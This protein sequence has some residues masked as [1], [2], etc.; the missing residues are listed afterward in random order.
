MSYETFIAMRHLKSRRQSFLSTITIIAILGVFLGV[1]A[2]TSVLAVTGGFQEAFRER[3]LGVNSHILVIKHGIDFRDYREIQE[4]IEGVPG[5]VATSPFIF[6]EMIATHGNRSA[7]ILIKGIEPKTIEEV[8]DLPRYTHEP[9][10][11]GTLE[12]DRFPEDGEL[13]VPRV[14]LG[15]AL[16]DK[17][18]V[19]KGDTIQVTSPLESLDPS[20]WSSKEHRPASRFFEVAGTYRSGFHEY[21]SRLVMVDYRALQDF[22]NQGDVV[23]GVDIR[24][25]DVFAVGPI[26]TTLRDELPLGRFRVLDW[27]QLNHNLFTSLGLQRLVL[28]ILFLFIVLVASFNIVCTLIMIVL[29]KNKD[30][31]ILKSMGASNWGIMKTFV[32][33][34]V[35]IGLVGTINGLIGGLAVCLFIKHTDFGLDPSIYMIDHLPVRLIPME[36]LSVGLV[37]MLISLVATIG[38]AYWAARLNPVDGLRYD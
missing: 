28:S 26:A 22:F 31:A 2:L 4:Q 7:G 23:T 3:V 10:V 1:M 6:H 17:L 9:G 35:T 16:A 13:P 36:F 14:L 25:E 33:Q 32:L 15:S 24:V 20:R 27:R 37:A 29:E 38:P 5:V 19:E 8:S 18:Q 21:D 34:G 12:F 11:V 30:I